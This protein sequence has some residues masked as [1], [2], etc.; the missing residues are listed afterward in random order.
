M[1][2]KKRLQW[3][4]FAEK[5]LNKSNKLHDAFQSF[6]RAFNA[7]FGKIGRSASADV[8]VELLKT[9]CMSILVYG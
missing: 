1:Q 5:D 4:G 8:V 2:K 6:Y 3:E 9:K 7:N